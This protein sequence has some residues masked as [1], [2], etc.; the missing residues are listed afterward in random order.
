VRPVDGQGLCF[1][2]A[3]RS[4]VLRLIRPDV[5]RSHVEHLVELARVDPVWEPLANAGTRAKIVTMTIRTMRF[6]STSGGLAWVR[7]FSIDPPL[8]K[9]QS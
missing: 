8:K 2:N 3:S 5:L 4:A 7:V 9:F 6:I 1:P